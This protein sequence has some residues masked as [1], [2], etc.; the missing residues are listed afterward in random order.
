[1]LKN[2]GTIKPDIFSM[3]LVFV[4]LI[5][6]FSLKSSF[7]EMERVKFQECFWNFLNS[8][9]KLIFRQK[10]TIPKQHFTSMLQAI[11]Q[12]ITY[13]AKDSKLLR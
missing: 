1:M 11:L 10:V 12:A 9:F 3:R 6:L 13:I 2:G 8:I 7:E 4:L 5:A